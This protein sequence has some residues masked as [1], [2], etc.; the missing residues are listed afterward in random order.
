[1]HLTMSPPNHGI[2]LL[3]EGYLEEFGF[4][5]WIYP[6]QKLEIYMQI[7]HFIVL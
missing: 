6:V 2:L 4:F 3:L 5:V 7:V 1:M